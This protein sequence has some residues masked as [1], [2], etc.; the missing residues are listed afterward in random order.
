MVW[1]SLFDSSSLRYESEEDRADRVAERILEETRKDLA[2]EEAKVLVRTGVQGEGPG[3][4][5]FTNLGDNWESELR[6]VIETGLA[7]WN[8]AGEELYRVVYDELHGLARHLMARERAGQRVAADCQVGRGAGQVGQGG[9]ARQAQALLEAGV[10]MTFLISPSVDGEVGVQIL[11]HFGTAEQ[12]AKYLQPLLD[13]AGVVEAP[14]HLSAEEA[15]TLP[16]AAVTAWNA[17]VAQGHADNEP[18]RL[19]LVDEFRDGIEV[20]AFLAVADDAE[21]VRRRGDGLADRDADTP[22]AEIKSENGFRGAAAAV[23]RGRHRGRSG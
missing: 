4:P 19:P 20:G 11:A 17:V 13:E 6:D 8:R 7:K 22:Q 10:K 2:A 9:L 3:E 16:C 21:R 14:A 23:R 18:R 12:K 15:A 5:D 1:D